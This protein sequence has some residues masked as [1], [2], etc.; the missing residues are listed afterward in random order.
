MKPRRLRIK[1]LEG[2]GELM[3]FGVQL[4]RI[5]R[6]KEPDPQRHPLLNIPHYL[7]TTGLIGRPARRGLVG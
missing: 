2:M 7:R 1:H 6:G 4:R 5:G 3:W